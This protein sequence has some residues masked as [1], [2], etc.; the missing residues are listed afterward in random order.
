MGYF[1]A[2]SA[3]SFK[4]NN[5]NYYFVELFKT[6]RFLS[7]EDFEK[8]R[9]IFEKFYMFSLGSIP[10]I[11]GIGRSYGYWLSIAILSFAYGY[12][13]FF[14]RSR[15][16]EITEDVHSNDGVIEKFLRRY[17][18]VSNKYLWAMVAFCSI[19]AFIGVTMTG[20]PSDY[21]KGLFV[22]GVSGFFTVF[23][24]LVIILR[25][26]NPV[27][28]DVRIDL[29]RSGDRPNSG[30]GAL[31]SEDC[32]KVQ[33]QEFREQ[34]KSTSGEDSDQRLIAVREDMPSWIGDIER[35]QKLKEKGA[36]TEHEF[37]TQKANILRN[38]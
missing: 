33:V 20:S 34:S 17:D 1:N 25:H 12:Y 22:A 32:K 26:A 21:E 8:Y 24:L 29:T 5:G 28:G 36:L 11:V 10:L 6:R 7:K 15:V 30:R 31:I 27:S 37:E 35:L 2:I 38:R 19:F 23:S 18:G 3:A 16:F 14:I 9:A 13:L 4:I